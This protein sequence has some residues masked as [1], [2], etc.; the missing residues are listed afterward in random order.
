MD[1][2]DLEALLATLRNVQDGAPPAPPAPPPPPAAP[3]PPAQADLD[4]LLSTLTALPNAPAHSSTPTDALPLPSRAR[5]V[6]K[7][8]FQEAVPILNSLSLDP[9]WLDKV[10][11]VWDEQKNW[12][13]RMKDE[14]NR[15]EREVQQAALPPATKSQ[16][17][18]DWDR[19]AMKK[20]TSLQGQQQEQ[21]QALGVP[22]FQKTSDSTLLKRQERVLGVLVGFLEDRD[23]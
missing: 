20:W 8:A 3:P 12:E 15:L 21:L 11:A 6:S 4:A 14:R 18:R 17:L 13:L 10:E 2:N 1:Q 22:T 16:K 19:A 9:A 23:G 5:D 7:V